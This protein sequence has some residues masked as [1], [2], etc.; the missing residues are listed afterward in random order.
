[1]GI[2]IVTGGM[3]GQL[4]AG[5][6]QGALDAAKKKQLEAEKARAA[7]E[8][9]GSFTQAMRPTLDRIESTLG[10]DTQMPDTVSVPTGTKF[11]SVEVPSYMRPAPNPERAQFKAI[12]EMMARASM[13]VKDPEQ[14]KLFQAA[15]VQELDYLARMQA[16]NAVQREI[17]AA[18]Q[19]GVLDEEVKQEF[20]TMIAADAD[21]LDVYRKFQG[22]KNEK[23]SQVKAQARGE[24]FVQ[25]VL[26][27]EA[28]FLESAKMTRD[29]DEASWLNQQ[30]GRMADLATEIQAAM[31]FGMDGFDFE[32][33]W[34]QFQEA[35]YALNPYQKQRMDAETTRLR[36]YYDARERV[37][38]DAEIPDEQ[39]GE[40]IR[41]ID[42][43]FGMG[44]AAPDQRPVG[45]GIALPGGQSPQSQPQSPS[46]QPQSQ[47]PAQAAPDRVQP[48]PEQA[49][50]MQSAAAARTTESAL[51]GQDPFKGAQSVE[52]I[53]RVAQ[54][55]VIG[56]LDSLL[57]GADGKSY[58]V[59][60]KEGQSMTDAYTERLLAEI[61]KL[62][63]QQAAR[64]M[65]QVR[66]L[67]AARREAKARVDAAPEKK[68][69][70]QKQRDD[71]NEA[72]S[73][74]AWG[75]A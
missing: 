19:S 27:D 24:R 42:Q 22:Y 45:W 54:E 11:G 13:N 49:A 69:K 47:A 70:A 71:M 55:K 38:T 20:L 56:M 18:E 73:G 31:A 67:A 39:K 74:A 33:A 12:T 30:S 51:A 40:M 34:E 15:A 43:Q 66:A 32:S 26:A 2:Q 16:A 68:A 29:P 23:V 44:S 7:Q 28:A 61:K 62:P 35:K 64:I 37:L 6:G 14:A 8:M 52:D 5:L 17:K 65:A 53:D 3:G 60:P 46:S 9:M 50:Q 36:S 57:L 4:G 48:T 63:E 75:G 58:E 59:T 72:M 21:P 25:Q 41:Q 10:Q 1:M